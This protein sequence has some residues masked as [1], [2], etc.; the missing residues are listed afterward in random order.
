MLKITVPL[1]LTIMK[2]NVLFKSISLIYINID[3]GKLRVY[4][5]L[6][7]VIAE[8]LVEFRLRRVNYFFH[9]QVIIS[10][11]VLIQLMQRSSQD[12]LSGEGCKS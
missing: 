5:Y 6:I 11:T 2:P 12:F 8:K 7:S 1:V 4:L 3:Y 10:V 9:V